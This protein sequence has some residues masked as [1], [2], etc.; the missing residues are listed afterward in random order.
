MR[1]LQE[2]PSKAVEELLGADVKLLGLRASESAGRARLWVDHGDY[3]FVKRYFGRNKGIWKANPIALWTDDDVWHYQQEN[4]IPHCELYD[5]G[6]PRNG[7]WPCA[8]AVRYGQ[9]RRLR[10][11]HPELFRHLITETKMGK[12]LLK[13]K[14]LLAGREGELTSEEKDVNLLL[15]ME[16]DLF[17][18]M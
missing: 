17:D 13:A 16:P 3:Y 18:R 10:E 7:C 12:E 8:M 14:L 5:K 6:Y 15:D 4:A 11:N 1:F 9:L 2:K